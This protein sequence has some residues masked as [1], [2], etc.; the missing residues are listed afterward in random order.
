[1]PLGQDGFCTSFLSPEFSAPPCSSLTVP[2]VIAQFNSDAEFDTTNSLNLERFASGSW[3]SAHKQRSTSCNKGTRR[4]SSPM[5]AT[6]CRLKAKIYTGDCMP[7]MGD[8]TQKL[9]LTLCTNPIIYS[10]S[11]HCVI[12]LISWL[13]FWHS[14]WPTPISYSHLIK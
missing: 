11:I 10:V 9:V 4:L 3:A 13:R 8:K 6:Y 12:W 5:V 1:M 2:S 14:F 7:C